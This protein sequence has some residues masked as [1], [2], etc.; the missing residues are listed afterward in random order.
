MLQLVGILD[1]SPAQVKRDW[2]TARAWLYREVQAEDNPKADS[3][4]GVDE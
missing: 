4:G 2:T 1:L 3:E